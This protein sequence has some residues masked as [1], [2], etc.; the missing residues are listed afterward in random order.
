MERIQCGKAAT[1]PALGPEILFSVLVPFTGPMAAT[2]A[3]AE[4][5]ARLAG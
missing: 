1:L 4:E 2:R 5:R 3:M